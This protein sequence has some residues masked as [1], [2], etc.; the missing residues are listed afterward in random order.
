MT[1]GEAQRYWI[2]LSSISGLGAK[3]FEKLMEEYGEPKYV[4]EQLVL[5]RRILSPRAFER[6][7]EARSD[8]YMESLFRRMEE[9]EIIAV[10]QL[11]DEYPDRLRTIDGAPHTLYVRGSLKLNDDKMFAIVGSRRTTQDGMRF[12]EKAAGDLAAAGVTIVSG[13][14]LGTDGKAHEG[15][16]NAG[17]RTIGVLAC[18]PEFIYPTEHRN[19]AERILTCGGSL[20]SEYPPGIRPEARFFPQRNRIISGLS[21]GVM[22]TEGM[23][24]SGAMITVRFAREQRRPCFAVPGSVYSLASEG[25]NQMLLDGDLP[26]ISARQVLD[27]FGWGEP[28]V[29][30][31]SQERFVELDAASQSLVDLLKFEEKSFDELTIATKMDS[32]S[33]NSLLTILEMQGI[34]RQSAGKMYRAV[35]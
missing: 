32:S 18:G 28:A 13:L 29:E 33:L 11:D 27:Y 1:Y 35:V 26:A 20:L 12:T 2:W 30:V 4:W 3:A 34:I 14:A 9:E 19:L 23:M 10:T 31:P 16:L 8:E 24:K 21:D 5:A 17:G 22:M 7:K 6:L 15:C 25:P